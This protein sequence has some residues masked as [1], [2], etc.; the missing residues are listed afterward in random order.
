MRNWIHTVFC[1]HSHEIHGIILKQAAEARSLNSGG[2]AF[3][4]TFQVECWL[5]SREPASQPPLVRIS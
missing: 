5:Q 4:A 2:V 1:L 3:S